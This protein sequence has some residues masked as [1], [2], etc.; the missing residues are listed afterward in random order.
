MAYQSGSLPSHVVKYL[1][2]NGVDPSKLPPDVVETFAGLSV[3]EVALLQ[4][5]G[6]SL[7]SV[8]DKEVVLRVH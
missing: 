5:I 4:V 1:E 2:R 3:G 6:D 7:Q 8:K